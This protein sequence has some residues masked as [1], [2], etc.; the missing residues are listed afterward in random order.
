MLF[1]HAEP[2]AVPQPVLRRFPSLVQLG[3]APR[4]LDVGASRSL[5]LCLLS[6]LRANGEHDFRVLA[7]HPA[8]P[9]PNCSLTHQIWEPAPLWC[10]AAPAPRHCPLPL[11]WGTCG[12]VS[13]G[14][15]G[16]LCAKGAVE[17][18]IPLWRGSLTLCPQSQHWGP[19]ALTS[20]L[21][22]RV[23][24]SVLPGQ[25][26]RPAAAELLQQAGFCRPAGGLGQLSRRSAPGTSPLMGHREGV[27]QDRLVPQARLTAH[28]AQHRTEQAG[29]EGHLEQAR[30]T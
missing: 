1:F 19:G 27:P 5:A 3:T 7:L 23:P 15:T 14:I 2:L 29:A 21:P 16:A 20:H 6:A 18:P 10:R 4:V 30:Y 17:R 8:Q 13:Q 24:G 22:S 9:H 26:C 12:P 11:H 25:R 28:P